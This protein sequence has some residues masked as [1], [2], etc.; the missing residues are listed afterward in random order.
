MQLEAIET[1]I[2]PYCCAGWCALFWVA[3]RTTRMQIWS[4][5]RAN[6]QPRVCKS[7]DTYS[8]SQFFTFFLLCMEDVHNTFSQIT[9]CTAGVCCFAPH[10]DFLCVYRRLPPAAFILPGFYCSAMSPALPA[11]P[12]KH[13]VFSIA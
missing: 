12:S 13:A 8:T 3:S 2:L 6:L 10:V 9:W 11:P 7:T 1:V 4:G 5:R